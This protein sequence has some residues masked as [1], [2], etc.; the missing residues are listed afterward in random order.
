MAKKLEKR[1]ENQRCRIERFELGKGG[2]AKVA[3]K[4]KFGEYELLLKDDTARKLW[5][6][7]I[8]TCRLELDASPDFIGD[9]VECMKVATRSYDIAELKDKMGGI[10]YKK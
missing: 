6:G 3:L 7:D 2:Y 4:T 10:I 1:L 5:L 8:L 9:R